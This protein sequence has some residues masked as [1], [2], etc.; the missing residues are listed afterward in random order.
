MRIPEFL[1]ENGSI[2]FVA[3]SFGCNIEPYKSAFDNAQKKFTQMGYKMVVGP[4]CYEGSG[5]GISNTPEKCG[6]ELNDFIINSKADV[7]I[8]LKKHGESCYTYDLKDLCRD[9]DML[10]G[11]LKKFGVDKN[12]FL[13][14]NEVIYLM[15]GHLLVKKK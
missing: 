5:I 14:E 2:G 4:N 15:P 12:T 8:S 13:N 9:I 3:P 6:D 7:I 1:K 10:L 11:I